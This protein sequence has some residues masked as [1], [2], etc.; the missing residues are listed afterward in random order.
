MTRQNKTKARGGRA[1]IEPANLRTITLSVRVSR[2]EYEAVCEKSS[3]MSFTPAR[4][5][6]DAALARRLPPAPAPAVNR[7]EYAE[8]ARLAGNINQ[9][10][11][12]AN[13]GE[14]VIVP[15]LLLEKTKKELARLRAAL[16]GIGGDDD[17]KSD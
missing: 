17:C 10:T 12:R 6:R 13:R 9:L 4:W 7:A 2:A 14:E 16:I 1:K 15:Y 11:W 5:L 3:A 8:L